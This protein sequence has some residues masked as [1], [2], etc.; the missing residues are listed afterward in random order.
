MKKRLKKYGFFV[1]VGLGIVAAGVIYAYTEFS[2]R[3]PDT[4]NLNAAFHFEA[5]DLLRL[6]EVE[7]SKAATQYA[8]KVISVQGFVSS[9][10][11]TDT[12]AIVFLNDGSSMSSVICQFDQKN[13]QEI[14]EL[15]K[16]ERITVKGVC[17]GYL[18]DVVMVRC[19]VEK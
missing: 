8:D 18:M 4:H 16:G 17:S 1:F 12:S 7:E 11:A 3:L 19:V 6:F 13:F 9:V 10:Q 14:L 5:D 2:R 15:Q